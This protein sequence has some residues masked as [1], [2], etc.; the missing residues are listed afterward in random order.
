MKKFNRVSSI[1][2][3][4]LGLIG[5]ISFWVFIVQGDVFED[6]YPLVSMFVSTHS[7]L[8]GVIFYEIMRYTGK[9]FKELFKKNN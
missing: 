6:W 5:S 3:F 8:I 7:A 9:S 4:I 1:I 2:V